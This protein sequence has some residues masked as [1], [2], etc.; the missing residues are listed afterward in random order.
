MTKGSR[1]VAGYD[2]MESFR[3][4]IEDVWRCLEAK[5]EDEQIVKARIPSH[6]E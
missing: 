3:E 6:A 1:N 5:S 2:P 4:K